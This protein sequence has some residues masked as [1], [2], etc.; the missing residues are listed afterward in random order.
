MAHWRLE[1]LDGRRGSRRLR[2]AAI[3]AVW[4]GSLAALQAAAAIGCE[5]RTAAQPSVE[6]VV[7]VLRDCYLGRSVANDREY[8]AP[9]LQ[10]RDG[11]VGIVVAGE[12]G[13]DRFRLRV[14]IAAE[15]R[16]VALWHTHGG[17]GSER[18][19]F[20]TADTRLANELGLASYL[21]TPAG[22]TRVYLPGSPTPALRDRFRRLLPRGVTAGEVVH[23]LRPAPLPAGAEGSAVA[24]L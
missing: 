6:A 24:S 11:Y 17:H 15:E 23:S 10:T 2:P 20:S 12:P 5:D 4:I 9:I 22:E 7:L 3:V 14:H 8:I 21:T 18:E 16:L 19:L 1:H 13:H